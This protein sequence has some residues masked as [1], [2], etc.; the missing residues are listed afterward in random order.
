VNVR[1]LYRNQ[2]G[3]NDQKQEPSA[4]D[5]AMKLEEMAKHGASEDAPEIVG[6]GKTSEDDS[7]GKYRHPY[8][9]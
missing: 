2:H 6:S 8:V 4:K 5:E 7:C 9:K 3:L 1:S